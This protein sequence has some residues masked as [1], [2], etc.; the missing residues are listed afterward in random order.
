MSRE[1]YESGRIRQAVQD[2]SREFITLMACV[3]AIGRRLPPTLLYTIES[4]DLLDT[5]V[6]D[7]EVG[8]EAYFGTSSNGWSNDA[9]GL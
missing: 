4:Y 3:S 7:L 8:D 1:A 6:A 5:W 9:F 2:G